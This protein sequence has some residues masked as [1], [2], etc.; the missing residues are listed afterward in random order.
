M[1]VSTEKKYK[2]RSGLETRVYATDH[3]AVFYPVVGAIKM[4]D[5]WHS[6]SWTKRG[7]LMYDYENRQD[8]TDEL[9][10][11]ETA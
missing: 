9:D 2:T 1:E 5:G 4:S 3:K 11:I 7:A 6:F 10:L 8:L